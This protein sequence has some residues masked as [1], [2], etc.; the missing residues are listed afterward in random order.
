[1]S[2]LLDFSF[3]L[4]STPV[5]ICVGLLI[6]LMSISLGVA[7]HISLVPC[8]ET[9]TLRSLLI[10]Y[11]CNVYDAIWVRYVFM[12]KM[13]KLWKSTREA[14]ESLL[15]VLIKRDAGTEYGKE[16]RLEEILS[17][18]EL[19][20][21]HPLTDYEHYRK[22]VQRLADGEPNVC[23]GE[24]LV[25]FGLTSGTTGPS[26]V[27]PIVKS[28][29]NMINFSIFIARRCVAGEYFECLSPAQRYIF[30]L[31]KY[32]SLKSK[33]GVKF[34]HA[35][36]VPDQGHKF[37]SMQ[38]TPNAGFEIQTD[39]ELL[40][41]HLLFGLMD[42]NLGAIYTVFTFQ[43][44]R[45]ITVLRENWK[46]LVDDIQ[47]GR[48]NLDL[49]ISPS[50][51][52]SLNSSLTPNP[53]RADELTVEFSK[54]F[55]GI[56][57]RVWPNLKLIVSAEQGGH[58]HKIKASGQTEGIP[59]LAA[60]YGS[61]EGEFALNLHPPKIQYVLLLDQAVYEFIPEK[62][63]AEKQPDTLLVDEVE[64]GERYELVI[65][66][67]SGLFRFRMGDMIQVVGFHEQCPIITIKERV[68]DVF[69]MCNE[70]VGLP[71]VAD[72]IERTVANCPEKTLFNWTCSEG[73]LLA[74]ETNG[75]LNMRYVLF[76]EFDSHCGNDLTEEQMCT[77]DTSLA[78]KHTYYNVCRQ[79]GRIKKPLVVVV[80]PGSFKKLQDFILSN[81]AASFNQFKMPKKL[82]TKSTLE[83]M[84]GCSDEP[85]QNMFDRSSN[86]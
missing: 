13:T 34:G 3:D 20:T 61:T 69:N 51:L 58:L 84:L 37:F 39:F 83:F 48:V 43:L 54:G 6:V 75:E 24:T 71:V 5:V 66:T 56:F 18:K 12:P 65:T 79:I 32:K 19:Q 74:D 85:F 21:K 16:H 35:I 26:K 22:Y 28:Q 86:S 2:F 62:H 23:V 14:Q 15:R 46:M 68:S 8:S 29:L 41:V 72:A 53:Q 76:L 33:S 42:R 63:T 1:M 80:K 7:L 77:F 30:C 45:V 81:S 59:I 67:R 52:E 50:I 70:R 31:S 36:Q 64:Q 73:T 44:A 47:T 9:H 78:E 27:I 4:K 10:C 49:N 17:L 38:N 57:A 60:D 40:Y 25:R 11:V 55:R 82:H